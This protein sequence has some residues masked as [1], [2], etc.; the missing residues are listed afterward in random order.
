LRLQVTGR[1]RHHWATDLQ[2]VLWIGGGT[3][4]GKTTVAK[5][6]AERHGLER[7]DYDWHDARDHSDRT[8]P[9]RHPTRSAFLALSMDERWVL[10]SPRDMAAADIAQ[11]AERFGM[12]LEDLAAMDGP[13]VVAEGFGL[14]PELVAPCLTSPRQ[15]IFLLPTPATRERNYASR[16]WAGIDGTSDHARASRNKLDRDALLTE[17]VRR[18][19]R[20]HDLATIEL[21]G[22]QPLDS[23]IAAVE[24]HF[25]LAR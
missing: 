4:A 25:G 6:I 2:R 23:V 16:G 8:A 14:L 12:V 18:T 19:A 9:D 22:S 15:A 5:A 10:R 7:Y 17:H 21:D 1:L 13:G 3:G 20:S 11:F 24:G